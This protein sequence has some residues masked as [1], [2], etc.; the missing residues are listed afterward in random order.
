MISLGVEVAYAILTFFDIFVDLNQVN[1]ITFFFLEADN[2][3]NRYAVVFV[4][5]FVA[6]NLE[7]DFGR[8]SF[9]PYV[10]HNCQF[11]IVCRFGSLL[12]YSPLTFIFRM[13]SSILLL[14]VLL[15]F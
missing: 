2:Y 12:I 13:Q 10:G 5:H 6:L 7:I 3:P 11:H 15:A 9:S 8:F 1:L 14:F 4:T